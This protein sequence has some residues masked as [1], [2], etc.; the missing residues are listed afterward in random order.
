[1]SDLMK[2]LYGPLDKKFC[3][4][5]YIL[6]VFSL[7]SAIIFTGFLVFNIFRSKLGN[8]EI[9]ASVALILLYAMG[10]LS[11]RILYNMCSHSL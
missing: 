10:Y 7:V 6:S 8:K 3:Y 11:N 4:Y 9:G 5:F 2:T 1:M